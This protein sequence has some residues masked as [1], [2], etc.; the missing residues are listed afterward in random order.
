MKRLFLAFD[1][2]EQL[3]SELG[4]RARKFMD[5]LLELREA[6]RWIPPERYHMTAV[7]LG[8]T[9]ESR[10]P[11]IREAMEELELPKKAEMQ[12]GPPMVFPKPRDPRVLV[13]ALREG[14]KQLE[15]VSTA[16][17]DSLGQREISFDEK[18]FRPHL[19]IGYLRKRPRRVQREIAN[20]WLR[21]TTEPS[22]SGKVTRIAL[23]ESVLS[24]E[25]PTYTL[26]FERL[27]STPLE[28][29]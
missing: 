8:D 16:L 11:R 22:G 17:R 7:F 27:L 28:K 1:I 5:G 26:L 6:V 12:L 10:L 19:T 3:R 23:Y 13:C 25:G 14:G 18:P 15:A 21:E 9:E 4:Q 2:D 20:R 24:P 29:R